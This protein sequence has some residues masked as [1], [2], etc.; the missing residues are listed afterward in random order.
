MQK[1][2]TQKE[3]K[4]PKKMLRNGTLSCQKWTQKKTHNGFDKRIEIGPIDQRKMSF[5]WKVK[6]WFITS[7]KH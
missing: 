7:E 5:V 3:K 2:T 1:R 4:R 6:V